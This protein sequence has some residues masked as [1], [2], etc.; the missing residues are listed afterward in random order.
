[1][2]DEEGVKL[3]VEEAQKV[4]PAEVSIY[5]GRTLYWLDGHWWNES[6]YLTTATRR[7]RDAQREGRRI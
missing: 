5:N 4:L 1:M 6:Q 3:T 2:N 7:L